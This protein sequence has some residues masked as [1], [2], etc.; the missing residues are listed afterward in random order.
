M[1]TLILDSEKGIELG[2]K[3]IQAGEVVAFPTETVYGLGGNALDDLLIIRLLFT[4]PRLMTYILWL[5]SLVKAT[6]D[7]LKDLCQDL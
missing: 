6:K 4:Y 5:Q 2:A 7:W 1:E 3:L